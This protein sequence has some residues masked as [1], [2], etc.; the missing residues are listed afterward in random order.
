M[1]SQFRVF[2]TRFGMA[3]DQQSL[4]KLQSFRWKEKSI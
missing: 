2:P 4:H 1:V 3:Q